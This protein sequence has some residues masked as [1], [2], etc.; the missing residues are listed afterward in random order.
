[1]I[2]VDG[3]YGEGGGSLVRHSIALSL[4]TQKPF[5]LYNIRKNRSKPGLSEQHYK[6][7]QL[8]LDVSDSKIV[9][10][11]KKSLSI[12]FYP[13]PIKN[14]K[15]SVAMSTAASISLCAQSIIL[16]YVFSEKQINM[17]LIGGTDVAHSPSI[18]YFKNVFLA[19]LRTYASSEVILKKRGYYP[20]GKGEVQIKIKGKNVKK[21]LTKIQFK[22]PFY[23]KGVSHCSKDQQ[24][25]NVAERQAQA[26]KIILSDLDMRVNIQTFYDETKSTGN[27][28]TLWAISDFGEYQHVIGRYINTFDN[29]KPE[30][31]GERVARS[32]KNNILSQTIVDKHQ[33]DQLILPICFVGGSLRYEEITSHAKS[34]M[35]LANLFLNTRFEKNEESKVLKVSKP[36]LP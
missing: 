19:E 15:I 20:K 26:S 29:V 36:Y 25:R 7:I 2:T 14:K 4:L 22:K 31:I 34:N 18:D 10:H 5:K 3:S 21:P 33:L 6:S 32:L 1:M 27:N 16:P 24:S 30:D 28:V 35:Y 13:K 23:V 17:E 12:E 11:R 8:A 9:G